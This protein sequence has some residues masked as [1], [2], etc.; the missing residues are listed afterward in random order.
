MRSRGQAEPGPAARLRAPTA[1]QAGR[2]E[3][4]G[5]E[6]HS[7]ETP[8]TLNAGSDAARLPDTGTV[9]IDAQTVR[10]KRPGLVE[11]YTVNMDG[12][13]QDFVVLERPEGNGELRLELEVAGAQAQATDS[14]ARLALENSGRKIAYSR[15]RVTDAT[16]RQLP[17]KMEA[18]IKSKIR[19]GAST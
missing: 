5:S 4:G 1:R 13:R 10:F 18:G 15:L 8:Q 12:V 3:R 6:P 17:A 19:N 2:A 11:E 16:G 9:A 14:G 7:V